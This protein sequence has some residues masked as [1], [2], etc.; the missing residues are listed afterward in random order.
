MASFTSDADPA[1]DE[2]LRPASLEAW[3][4]KNAPQLGDG[5]LDAVALQGGVSN[6][7]Y[8]I[9]RGE[10]TAVLR[11]PPRVPRPDS[12]KIIEIGR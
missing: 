2:L 9:T 4:D 3:L 12:F 10:G 1:I 5:H 6:A 8:R 7:V 11:R